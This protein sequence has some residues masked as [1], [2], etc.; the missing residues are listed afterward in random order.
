MST[1]KLM[2]MERYYRYSVMIAL[3]VIS[4]MRILD[5]ACVQ[6]C[7]GKSNDKSD[8]NKFGTDFVLIKEENLS[9]G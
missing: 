1:L 3:V 6:I 4:A 9:P 8:T 2:D 5:I 7:I